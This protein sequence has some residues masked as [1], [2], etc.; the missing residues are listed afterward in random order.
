MTIALI[1]LS[2]SRQWES[3]A[4]HSVQ[5]AWE[6]H[7][8]E[9]SD[10]SK[11]FPSSKGDPQ[12]PSV[13]NKKPDQSS[14]S[15]TP[16]T[17]ALLQKVVPPETSMAPTPTT[18]TLAP[19]A[20]DVIPDR[21]LAPPT[22]VFKEED[23]E[24]HQEG[25]GR[26]TPIYF[27]PV[28]SVIHWEKQV[29]HF[30][31]PTESI[32]QLPTG[33]PIS[34]PKIQYQFSDETISARA[35]REERLGKVKE[36]FKKAWTGYRTYA[37]MHDE[38]SPVSGEYRDPFAGWAATLVDSLD[39]LFI[40]GLEEEFEDAVKAVG[41]IDFTT[42]KRQ[43]IQVFETTIRYLGGL[44]AAYDVSGGT[45]KVLLEKAIEL[46]EVMIG[47]FDTPNRMPV[48]YYNWKPTFA[49]QPHRASTRSNLAELGS[50]SMEFTHLAQLTMEPK[51]YDVVARITNA[52]F[53]WQSR[54]TTG[55]PGVFPQDVD[56][57]GC[58]RSLR[59]KNHSVPSST[60]ISLDSL[61][62]NSEG[63]KPP[64][65]RPVKEPK[66]IKG[67][68]AKELADI[69]LS[70]MPGE[71]SKALLERVL[72]KPGANLKKISKRAESSADS[73]NA[74]IAPEVV[75]NLDQV[76]PASPTATVSELARDMPK[77]EESPDQDLGE[78]DCV[79]QGLESANFGRE[80]FSMGGSQD[81]TYEYFS[82]VKP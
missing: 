20:E 74:T 29:E 80:S 70:V 41:T 13:D 21:T 6:G 76:L 45:K 77:T 40:M 78:W 31:V 34:I 14:T 12:R 69:Y 16:E 11:G 26:A 55:L 49:S 24:V 68:G 53:E 47:V 73:S 27:S 64:T 17:T 10:Q 52:L 35:K 81:S 3:E 57:S 1:R 60:P 39:T 61:S 22:Q 79:P 4:S 38:L 7:K 5:A 43:D 25:P 9:T 15:S 23:N 33:K 42:A 59:V 8:E 63:Y 67:K 50:L 30:P 28:P 82:K 62:I 44:L 19:F 37:W 75:T 2:R 54:G 66:P 46:A 72:P 71:P 32:I 58:N 18:L 51:Y 36:E 48:L 65:P 56:A